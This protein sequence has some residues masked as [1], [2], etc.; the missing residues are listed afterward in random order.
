[1][2]KIKSISG[3]WHFG[4][5]GFRDLALP[6]VPEFYGGIGEQLFPVVR[7]RKK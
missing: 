1:M 7:R 6:P 2:V 5:C 3:N 4:F